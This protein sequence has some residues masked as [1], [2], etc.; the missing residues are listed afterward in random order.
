MLDELLATKPRVFSNTAWNHDLAPAADGVWSASSGGL[1]RWQSDGENRVFTTEGGLPFNHTYALLAVPDGSLWVAANYAVAHI[2]PDGDSLGQIRTYAEPDGL[3]LGEF[4]TLMVDDDDSIWVA[5]LYT[6]PPIY[7]FNGAVWRP[8]ELPL[9]DPVVQELK[10]EI[11]TMLRGE[12]G[13]LWFG[14]NSDGI[15]RLND[16]TWTHFG[17]EQGVPEQNISRLLEDSAGV[18]WAAAGEAGLLRFVPE[19]DRWQR[20]ELQRADAPVFWIAQL[21]DESLWASGDDFIVRSTDGGLQWDLAAA[22]ADGLDYP[23][24]VV[25][26][27]AGR[28]W[29]ATGNGVGMYDGEQWR[30]WQRS[31]E[32]ADDSLG[33]L[34]EAPD[35]K[36]WVLPAYGGPPS[37]VDP[38]TGQVE[39]VADL[40][41]SNVRTRWPLMET[42]SGPAHP[43]GCCDSGT[44]LGAC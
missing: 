14:L 20:V 44:D 26:D 39:G 19:T 25:P 33:Q 38:A 3:P 24:A 9:D 31:G 15:L 8:P 29:V 28:I 40:A 5:S 16:S 4:P 27:G 23:T 12:D 17:A 2:S 22:P 10:L 30:S 6:S 42:Q 7:R 11:A 18:L 37:V 43:T 1:M 32:L 13:A 21:P 36:L 35:G 34:F 41:E